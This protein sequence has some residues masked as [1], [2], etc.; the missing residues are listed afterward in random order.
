MKPTIRIIKIRRIDDWSLFEVTFTHLV[1]GKWTN[2]SQ[3]HMAI[4]KQQDELTVFKYLQ[5]KYNVVN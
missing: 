3:Q 1:D 4:D 5:H 2:V